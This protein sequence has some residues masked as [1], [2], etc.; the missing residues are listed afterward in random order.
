[1]LL[2]FDPDGRVR[3][4]DMANL[5]HEIRSNGHSAPS[6]ATVDTKLEVVSYPSR[7]FDRAKE[8]YARLGWR[9]DAGTF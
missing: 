9:L 7:K 5:T 2:N 4:K 1:M 3:E 8:F 6:V